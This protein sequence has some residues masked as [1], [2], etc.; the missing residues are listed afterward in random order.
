M[1]PDG[2]VA[3]AEWLKAIFRTRT[4]F[5]RSTCCRGGTP[6]FLPAQGLHFVLCCENQLSVEFRQGLKSDVK[7]VWVACV[8]S[9][10]WWTD[11]GVRTGA[12]GLGGRRGRPQASRDRAL[13]VA[14]EEAGQPVL[15]GTWGTEELQLI[16]GSNTMDPSF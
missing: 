1:S 3:G 7:S 4:S 9:R 10:C 6:S 12:A 15:P 2:F 8:G 5:S 14:G 16:S 13:G 11:E